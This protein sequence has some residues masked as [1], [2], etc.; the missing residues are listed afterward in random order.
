MTE[1]LS[2]LS[3]YLIVASFAFG[4][5]EARAANI[6]WI[7]PEKLVVIFGNAAFVFVD[8]EIQE[9]T[10]QQFEDFVLKNNV[11]ANS[12]VYFNSP[13]GNLM[14]GI[15]LGRIIRK[16]GLNTG[17]AQQ[18]K[19][20]DSKSRFPSGECYSACTLSFMGGVFRYLDDRSVFGVHRFYSNTTSVQD[21]DIA[22][23]VSAEEI[24]YLHEMG[25]DCPGSGPIGQTA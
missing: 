17:V 22:Q 11:A 20:G 3:Q 19:V 24:N 21:S 7:P 6:S 10:P 5:S 2:R 8:G 23:I 16:Y 14:A 15:K 18:P 1:F 12:V 25:I 4:F 13:G 9:Q